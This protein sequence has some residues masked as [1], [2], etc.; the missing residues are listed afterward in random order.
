MKRLVYT[1]EVYDYTPGTTVGFF[2]ITTTGPEE[3]KPLARQ[4]CTAIAPES[5][6]YDFTMVHV[7]EE[8]SA[9]ALKAVGS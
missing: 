8:E 3:L 9:S 5:G 4:L 7:R 6:G 1:I 2:N